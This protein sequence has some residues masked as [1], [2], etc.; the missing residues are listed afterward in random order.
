MFELAVVGVDGCA[1]GGFGGISLAQAF[2]NPLNVAHAV[3]VVDIGDGGERFGVREIGLGS[4]ELQETSFQNIE[5]NVVL[6]F[7]KKRELMSIAAKT[8][9]FEELGDAFMQPGRAS[10]AGELINEGVRQFMLQHVGEFGCHGTETADGNAE[11]AVVHRSGPGG[12]VGDIE[13]GLL[14]VESYENVVA[15]GVAEIADKVVIVGLERG[16]DLGAEHVG[17]LVAFV[18][19][20][21]VAAFALGKIGFDFLLPLGLSQK[22]L[23]GG[24]GTQFKGAFPG[25]HGILGVVGGELD[26]AEHGVGVGRIGR[27]ANGMLG[28]RQGLRGI[29]GSNQ[30]SGVISK[31]G[32][33]VG[34]ETQSTL[35]VLARVGNVA[36]F[37]LKFSGNE[38]GGCAER[39][40]SFAFQAG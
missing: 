9:G 6:R 27:D 8:L 4:G 32:G 2:E 31:D 19:Q 22:L 23:H 15:W 14:G 39:G 34:L 18:V 13:K 16:Q 28:V 30:D 38:I 11:L 10:S 26:I 40:V 35:K 7:E 29:A 36:V 21:E 12:S 33:V 37:E 24:I 25:S 3:G 1:Q 5:R 17:G 20:N